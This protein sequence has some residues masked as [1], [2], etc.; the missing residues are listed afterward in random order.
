MVAFVDADHLMATN[1][2]AD[3]FAASGGTFTYGLAE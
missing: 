3:V 2:A 1:H